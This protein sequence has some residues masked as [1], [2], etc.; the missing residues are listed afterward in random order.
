MV[1]AEEF[2]RPAGGEG[3]QATNR[4]YLVPFRLPDLTQAAP[5][6]VYDGPV[7]WGHAVLVTGGDV[8]VYGNLQRDS[9][10]NL[11]YLARFPLGHA[12]GYWQFWNGRRFTPSP[13]TAAPLQGP[14][15]RPLVAKLASVIPHPNRAG[16]EVAA[17]SIDPL[18]TTID[19]RVASTPQGP[20]STRHILYTVPEPHP[21]L[22]HA[23]AGPT[24]TTQLAYS[25]ANSRPRY[26]TVRW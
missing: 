14:D 13:L 25:V 24:G 26:L 17:L 4:R 10:T 6:P 22:P 3:F 11:T 21:Y 8:Y 1:F 20:W 18:S 2:T 23:R 5:R 9:S 15:G 16:H 12:A 7:A 19:L